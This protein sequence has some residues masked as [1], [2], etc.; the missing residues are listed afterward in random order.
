MMKPIAAVF[1]ALLLSCSRAPNPGAWQYTDPGAAGWNVAKLDQARAFA[2]TLDTGALFVV[3]RG[4]VILDYGKSSAR[5]NGQSM[6]KSLLSALVGVAV[7]RGQIRMDATLAELGI[8]DVEPLTAAEKRATVRDLMMSRSGV[9]HS[10]LYETRSNK[11]SKPPRGSHRPGQF[12]Y[13]NNWDFNT[14]GTIYEKATGTKIGEA[15]EREIAGP[16][17]MDDFRARDVTYLTSS[18]ISERMSGNRSNQRAYVFMISARDFARIGQLYL[19][20]GRWNG[21]QILPAQWVRASVQGSEAVDGAKYGFMW[22]VYDDGFAARGFRGHKVKVFPALDL[23]IVHRVPTGG[24]GLV[25]QMKR[26][27]IGAASVSEPDLDK[28]MKMIVDACPG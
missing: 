4:K 13:Y 21:R 23:V 19:N 14:V 24:V 5:W 1:L 9:Y 22:W 10:A 2:E 3:H 16:L 11:E 6:R 28:L 26:R 12:F 8:D 17:Q 18:S 27:F 25:A 20:E 7:S 15:F